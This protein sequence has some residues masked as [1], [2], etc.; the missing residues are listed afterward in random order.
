[1]GARGF[2]ADT[3]VE[4]ALR[5]APMIPG[6]EGST[7]INFRLTAQF[8]ENYFA[9]ATNG[10]SCPESVTLSPSEPEENPYWLGRHDRRTKTVRFDA[11]LT[12]YRPL[13]ALPN[14]RTFVR[15]AWAFRQLVVG[16]AKLA[17]LTVDPALSIAMGRCFSTIVYAQLV[18]ENCSA[19]GVSFTV[20][21]TVFHELIQDL[22]AEALR[23]MLMFPRGSAARKALR[24]LVRVPPASADVESVFQLLGTLYA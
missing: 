11:C 21:S 1:L 15:Q 14:V 20:V 5:E 7:H 6:L 18:A 10:P 4:T 9:D 12:A 3:F 16:D 17:D 8:I 24:K 2:E 19:A 23:L 13:R 22:T